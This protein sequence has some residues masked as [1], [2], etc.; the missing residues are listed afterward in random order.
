MFKKFM[1][2]LALADAP[3]Q[4]RSILDWRPFG[5]DTLDTII[6]DH[7]K[8]CYD[9]YLREAWH[10][11]FIE[12][13]VE[14]IT[15]EPRDLSKVSELRKED[16]APVSI[17]ML[18]HDAIQ[19]KEKTFNVIKA[20]VNLVGKIK[21]YFLPQISL[22][23]TDISY[24]N[25]FEGLPFTRSNPEIIMDQETFVNWLNLFCRAY[26]NAIEAVLPAPSSPLAT[27]KTTRAYAESIPEVASRV[28]DA[29]IIRGLSE[30]ETRTLARQAAM[31]EFALLQVEENIRTRARP[32]VVLDAIREPVV[33]MAVEP[34]VFEPGVET[35]VLKP[36]QLVE[37]YLAAPKDKLTPDERAAVRGLGIRGK[38]FSAVHPDQPATWKKIRGLKGIVETNTF[39]AELPGG[40]KGGG[41]I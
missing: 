41:I 14:G 37:V 8:R 9:S 40:S 30:E 3:E 34:R 22:R 33:G 16:F 7:N 29:A 12:E 18:D 35:S 23:P 11:Q 4:G 28:R 32:R 39:K 1:R 25:H 13:L 10:P 24:F 31:Q 20:L 19:G 17:I 15:I 5:K 21:E 2:L 27:P 36:V 38:T 26:R 6:T